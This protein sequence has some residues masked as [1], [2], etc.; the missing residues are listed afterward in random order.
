MMERNYPSSSFSD[1]LAPS[2]QTAAWAYERAGLKPSLSYGSGPSE[3]DLLHR[4]AYTAAQLPAYSAT[5]HPTGLAGIFDTSL[6]GAGIN[7]TETSVMNFLSAIESRTAASSGATLLPQFRAASWQTAMHSTAD[8]FVTGALPTSGTFPP[9]SALS[10]YQHP[11]TF[12]TRNFAATPTLTLQ[13]GTFTAASNGLLAH[14]P[15]LQLKTSQCTIPT[16]LTFDRLGSSVLTSSLPPQSSTYR[17]AQESAPHLLQPQF[18]LLPSALAGAQQASQAYSPAVF[19]GSTASIERALQRECSVIKHHQRPSSTQSVQAQLAGSHHSLQTYLSS[20]SGIHFQDTS[21]Q[22]TLSCSPL[23]DITQVSN[24]GL[25]QKTSRVTVELA[26]SYTSAI[27]SSGYPLS[28]AKGKN[29]S[30]KPPPISTKSSKPQSVV[31]PLQTQSY[32]KSA[33]SQGSVISTQAQIYSTAQLPNLLSVSQSQTFISTQ[34]PNIP[35]ISASQT[36][37]S[38]KSEKLPSLYKNMNSFSAQTQAITSDSQTVNYSTDQ[39]HSLPSVSNENYSDQAR[40]LSSATPSQS[41]T[42][43]QSQGLS[44]LSQSPINYSSQSHAA[45]SV[46][47]SVSY[48]SGQNLSSS[49]SLQFS[50]SSVVQNLSTSSPSQNYVSMPSSQS[51]RSQDSQSPQSQTFLP[52]SQ[53]PFTSPTRPQTLHNSKLNSDVKTYANEGKLHSSMYSS[54][55]QEAEFP[56]QD[57]QALQQHNTMESSARRLT[58]HE[59]GN[60]ELAYRVSKADERYHSPSVIRSSSRLDDQGIGLSLQGSKRDERVVSSVAPVNQ[61]IGHIDSVVNLDLKHTANIL[62]TSHERAHA[63]E[64]SQQ[65]QVISKVLETKI[66]E[67]VG[68]I[69][70]TPQTQPPALR[71]AQQLPLQN[72]QALLE[73][74]CDLEMLQQS[75]FGQTKASTQVP[76]IHSTQQITHPFLQMEAH[77]I[78]NNIGQP[79]HQTQNSDDMKMDVTGPEKSIQHH[80]TSIKD[81]FSH[82]NPQDSKNQFVSLSSMC[83]PES[84][85]LTDERNIL[86]NVDDILAATAAACGV[87]TQEFAKASSNNENM[88]EENGNDS[89]S[90]YQPDGRHL[91]PSFNT[92]QVTVEKHENINAE[93]MNAGQML[94]NLSQM[95]TV[96]SKNVTFAK[97]DVELSDQNLCSGIGS[98]NPRPGNEE[99]VLISASVNQQQNTNS[100]T[101]ENSDGQDCEFNNIKDQNYSCGSNLR[102]ETSVSDNDFNRCID[103]GNVAKNETMVLSPKTTDPPSCSNS[104]N[105]SDDNN[106]A[107]AHSN[108]QI[109]Q[110]TSHFSNKLV[111]EDENA[112]Q[113]LM[114]NDSPVKRQISKGIDI[115]LPCSPADIADSY[116]DSFQHQERIRQKI[117]EVEEQ[118]PEVKSGFIGSF[119]DF[120]KG[121]PKLSPPAKVPS[122]TKRPAA[123]ILRA[124]FLQHV[125]FKNLPLMTPVSPLDIEHSETQK[126]AEDGS[127]KNLET[128]PSFSSSDEDSGGGRDLQNSIS[129]ALSALDDTSEKKNKPGQT[130]TSTPASQ[131]Q[132]CQR[133]THPFLPMDSH[134]NYSNG[135]PSRQQLYSQQSEAMKMDITVSS[136][137]LQQQE[138]TSKDNFIQPSQYDL[139][140]KVVSFGSVCFPESLLLTDKRNTISNTNDNPAATACRV[141]TQEFSKAAS[142]NGNM[143]VEN[144]DDKKNH[145]EL[146]VRQVSPSHTR[147]QPALSDHEKINAI[148]KK[149]GHVSINIS[150]VSTVKSNSLT[151]DKHT[152]TNDYSVPSETCS[153]TG[154][155]GNKE[156]VHTSATI[157]RQSN[158]GQMIEED[159]CVQNDA[160]NKTRNQNLLS[161]GSHLKEETSVRDNKLN[162]GA[163]YGNENKV[164]PLVNME[165]KPCGN[166]GT[167]TDHQSKDTIQ[168]QLQ[169]NQES[170]HFTNELFSNDENVNQKEKNELLFKRQTSKGI[171]LSLPYSPDDITD[172]YLD[173]SQHQERIRQKIKEVEEQQPEVKSGFIGSFLDFLKDEPKQPFSPPPAKELNQTKRPAAPVLRAPFLQHV[174]FTNLPLMT[175]VAPLGIE[176]TETLNK[177]ESGL[178]ENL[179]TVPSFSSSREDS[180]GSRSM[181]KS[182]P[183]AL[184]AI[185][186]SSEK[187][188]KADSEK[189]NAAASVA[190]NVKQEPPCTFAPA[191]K[192]EEKPKAI[193]TPTLPFFDA[194]LIKLQ[195]TVAFEGFTEDEQSDS[196]GEGTF[197]ERDEFVVKLEDMDVLKVA[198]STGQEPPAIWKVQKALLQKFVPEVRGGQRHYSATNSYLGYFGDAKS[199]Y[200][201]V[202]AKFIENAN[203]KEYVRICSRKPRSKLT[204]SARTGQTKLTPT[205]TLDPHGLK[206][207]AKQ[208]KS[209]AEPPPKKR[210]TWKEECTSFQPDT[211]L[212]A[213]MEKHDVDSLP[214]TKE[215]PPSPK[216]VPSSPKQLLHSEKQPLPSTMQPLPSTMQPLPSTMQP[217]PSTMQPLPSTMQP[218]PSTKQPSPP[219]KQPS[220]STK[221][222]SPSTKQPSPSTK[223]PSPSTKQPSPSTKQP[224]PSTKQP[225]PST[226]QP[227]LSTKRPPQA[228][229]E[230]QPA[231]E[232][233]ASVSAQ[234]EALPPTKRTRPPAKRT[235]PPP[236]RARPAKKQAPPL[237]EEQPLPVVSQPSLVEEHPLSAEVQPLLAEEQPLPVQQQPPPAEAQPWPAEVQPPVSPKQPP[238]S[239]KQPP[240]SPKLTPSTPK[241]TPSTPKQTPLT[242]ETPP[243]VSARALRTRAMKETFRSYMELLVS[244]ALDADTMQALEASSDELLLPHMRKIDG[245]LDDSQRKVLEKLNLQQSH[246]SALE[247]YPELTVISREN[248]SRKGATSSVTK[249]KVN[250]KAY[251]KKTLQNLKSPSKSSKEFTVQPERTPLISL[252]HSLHHYKYHM[253]LLCKDEISTVMKAS[254]DVGQEQIVHECMKNLTWVETLFERFGELL[255]DV[256]ERCS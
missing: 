197:R 200:K 88:S 196:G 150:P 83:F 143:S 39:Q 148:F 7:T 189:V 89:K 117:K 82:Q 11:S 122:R 147:P 128:L 240:S 256:Q 166:L 243:N 111:R 23:A 131:I 97:K 120:L 112:N 177:K 176:S 18:S 232:Q 37:S 213:Q 163:D 45:L 64:L 164:L 76:L 51:S 222:P 161:H 155:H 98:P 224:S 201:R 24:G 72:A 245:M 67:N 6:H 27:P 8:L 153:S 20:A 151:T 212:E 91:S 174:A 214:T 167:T 183:T 239:P 238:V 208:P 135:G 244:M 22:S 90:H 198:L 47:S 86:S 42:S 172:S 168:S 87:T 73:S 236:K 69:P 169:K 185:D 80:K 28:S 194:N 108:P 247:M 4:Q 26:Q 219:A 38:I 252:Y 48:S 12:S 57:L 157:K 116:F 146:K 184:S 145:F 53:S 92:S 246:K 21:R 142:N 75:I 29:C 2:A 63:K 52:S 210:K 13:D 49:P 248:K 141:A 173:G 132:S 62:Q 255:S 17:S 33:Q 216:E 233:L 207:K 140:N 242:P 95:T 110:E 35:T 186:A 129:T 171:D 99:H 31:L 181:R 9:T 220:P 58:E 96:Q 114:T 221:Q 65:S 152:E 104:G 160:F 25:Q 159:N 118:Q 50:S 191:I 77:D 68:S 16:A 5:H 211:P 125:P 70:S 165:T 30:T 107:T 228:L 187:K 178:K 115:S 123:P 19:A 119:L 182:M 121:E 215:I 170:A 162:T 136:K 230:V 144:R 94:L 79:Q 237:A 14:D 113:K 56:M 59:I 175:P 124:P 71:Q 55:K 204:Q 253:F 202:Y 223:Q 134:T 105:F 61:H 234:K 226:K 149:N 43:N 60:P 66:E 209:K 218:L 225:S 250:G 203:K 44:P 251:N 1:P 84:M 195:G 205:K 254:K 106:K 127:K 15:L 93:S 85:L 206:S 130:K 227:S 179:E 100:S 180:G 32:A 109:S 41:Y 137:R 193:E 78:H 40:N 235:R 138:L 158:T 102:E 229:K 54:A 199:K 188:K 154:K 3:A 74:A 133:I 231:L 103:D 249:I 36:F 34:S 10:A 190:P 46:S 217:L 192:V 101:E 139:K 156:Q 241:L 81:T 126:V